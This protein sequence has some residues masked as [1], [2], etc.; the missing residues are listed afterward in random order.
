M[1]ASN[2][3]VEPTPG[4][5]LNTARGN[6][7]DSLR[8]VMTNFKSTAIPS[9]I[10]IEGVAVGEQDG[11]L[12]RSENTNA[13][14]I[15]DINNKKTS[16]IGGNFTRTG[17][18]CRIENG[19][20]ALGANATSYE[21]GELVAT[22][23][24]NG[25][26]A[27]NAR[28]YLC[29]TNS[30]VSGSTAGFL[31]IG[32]TQGYSIGALNNATFSGQSVTGIRLLATSNIAVGTTSPTSLLHIA[33]AE[34]RITIEETTPASKWELGVATSRF[35]LK[36]TD[37]GN[38]ILSFSNTA[39]AN[40][41]YVSDAG[42]L[43][44]GTTSP[45]AKLHLN[46]TAL[47]SQVSIGST[48]NISMYTNGVSNFV[49]LNTGDLRIQNHSDTSKYVTV[50]KATGDLTTSGSTYATKFLATTSGSASAPNYSFS[51]DTNTGTYWSSTT[52]GYLYFSGSG[53]KTGEIQPGG[54]LVMVGEVTAYSDERLKTNVHTITNALDKVYNMRGVYF[55]KDGKASTG[56]IA[57]EIEKILPE[58]VLDGEYK[59]VAYGNIVGILIEAIKEL[60]DEI[61]VLRNE[62]S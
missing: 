60:K 36:N 51:S 42:N 40:S 57:Q 2:T 31:D 5:S 28:L 55:T 9:Q 59:S 6:F 54:N 14:Y 12:F 32:A 53:V 7:N 41:F 46:G 48:S 15:S 4:T 22:V 10:T 50:S 21:I 62:T 24:E 33:S 17:I 56:V 18:G 20:V 35:I 8:A 44:I 34:P 30:T 13:L 47:S 58:V 43:G 19:I 29:T 26:L 27:S 39:P 61:A 1:V 3:Y 38:T 45:T 37:T 25:T 16:P 49:D 52:P 23:S 11:M